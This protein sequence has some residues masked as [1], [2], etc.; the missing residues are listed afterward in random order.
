MLTI[1]DVLQQIY[2]DM[3]TTLTQSLISDKYCQFQKYPQRFNIIGRTN[4]NNT[5]ID[6][7]SDTNISKS[8]KISNTNNI[9]NNMNVANNNTGVKRESTPTISNTTP[10]STDTSRSTTDSLVKEEIVYIL[11]DNCKRSIATNRFA[12][13]L[14]RCLSARTR[15]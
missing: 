8:H 4:H 12:A 15:K 2:D 14:E 11:C 1:E 3:V 13:H 10:S 7:K 5:V 6:I 9:G